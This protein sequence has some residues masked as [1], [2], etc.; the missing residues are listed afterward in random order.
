MDIPILNNNGNI[1]KY[2][3]EFDKIYN[4]NLKGNLM[5]PQ[6]P[7]ED[8]KTDSKITTY[9]MGMGIYNQ[10]K[11]YQ[12]N[13]DPNEDQRYTNQQA[14]QRIKNNTSINRPMTETEKRF[15]LYTTNNFDIRF[16]NDLLNESIQN[17]DNLFSEFSQDHVNAVRESNTTQDREENLYI[18]GTNPLSKLANLLRAQAQTQTKTDTG[19]TKEKLTGAIIKGLFD[20]AKKEQEDLKE[21]TKL[22]E[23]ATGTREKT[24]GERFDEKTKIRQT[25]P[26]PLST[27]QFGF[28]WT[29]PE[30]AQ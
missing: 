4:V 21:K 16:R 11:L 12:N 28:D 23:E 5:V 6:D 29:K 7:I 8:F 26:S 18:R 19:E 30:N 3:Q 2:G 15:N 14:M 22:R 25:T 17:N 13:D 1:Q 24:M 27:F 9:D 20:M 10:Q